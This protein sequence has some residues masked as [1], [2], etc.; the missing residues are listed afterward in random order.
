MRN[1]FVDYEVA[2]LRQ[3]RRAAWADL[4]CGDDYQ[5]DE[6]VTATFRVPQRD[7]DR[8]VAMFDSWLTR[9]Y[10]DEAFIRG[11]V[12]RDKSG[13]LVGNFARKWKKGIG[14]PAYV[15]G[16]EK[17]GLGDNHLHAIIAHHSYRDTIRRDRGWF[18]W[19]TQ[20]NL[21]RIRIEPPKSQGDIVGYVTKYV[22]KND[23]TIRISG[24]TPLMPATG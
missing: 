22:I 20:M 23:D 14:R 3:E 7:Q 19:H 24:L 11:D 9:R 2:E 12:K 1:N 13:R 4:L 15:L 21:G 16:I 17:S 18:I 10:F 5:W 6:F 8:A